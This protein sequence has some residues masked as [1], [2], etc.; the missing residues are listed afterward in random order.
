[1]PLLI[2]KCL[3][4]LFRAWAQ[5]RTMLGL[6]TDKPSATVPPPHSATVPPPPGEHE[7]T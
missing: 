3:S 7:V 2:L 1:M 4:A 5:Y 6:T